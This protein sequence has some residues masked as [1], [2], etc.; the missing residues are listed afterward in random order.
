MR[1]ED[2][3]T[4]LEKDCR[5]W[6]KLSL[7]LL[8]L[9]L[10]TTV[11]AWRCGVDSNEYINAETIS[12]WDSEERL[13]ISLSADSGGIVFRDQDQLPRLLFAAPGGPP[14]RASIMLRP[15]RQQRNLAFDQRRSTGVPGV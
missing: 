9:L 8:I 1:I 4:R 7:A 12:L 11:A 15:P 5:R 13:R 14:N 10:L 3:F 2:L 6:Q